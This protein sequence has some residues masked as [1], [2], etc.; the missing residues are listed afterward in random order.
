LNSNNLDLVIT[1]YISNNI[2]QDD[3][4]FF[5]SKLAILDTIGC[6]IEASSHKEVVEFASKNNISTNFQNPFRNLNF[7]E[8]YENISWYLTVL[9]R[10]FDY[11]DTFLAKEWA[12]P[13]D[14]FGTIYSYFYKNNNYK[15]YDFVNSLTKAYEIQ[16]SLCLGTSLNK[17]GYDHV[18]YVKLASGSVFSHL[19]NNGD[20]SATRRTVNNILLDGPS[21]RA[22]RH[23]P[24]VGKRKSWAAADAAKRG[25]ELA[26]ISTYKDE[27]YESVQNEDKWGFEYSF[28]DNT[29]LEIG[30]ELNNWVIQNTLFK[31]LFPAEFHGQSAV[32]AAIELSEEFNKNIN[33]VK[34]INIYTHEPAIRIISNKE[35]LKNASDRD[36]SLEYMVAAALL[37]GELKYEMYEENYP[38]FK[39][40]NNLRKKIYVTEEP[41]FTKDYY[42][43]TK[44]HISNSIEIVFDDNSISEKVTIENPIGHP[45]RREEAVPLLKDK[46]LR[47]VISVFEEEK[48]LE[49]WNKIINL[50]KDDDLNMFFNILNEDE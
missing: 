25:I 21:L 46:F 32:E 2:K 6:I 7:N 24:N 28:L 30:K 35:I 47:N 14:N 33:K 44:R 48:A 49:V 8:S 13:S 17:L 38:G 4:H 5:S 27:I 36:H 39:K 26:N 16:G 34:K 42:E 12:H 50:E 1:E 11:N 45:S 15:F 10:W 20:R 19:V 23:F 22:Y 31:V 41:Q 18:F 9:T 43:F 37:Y 3:N 40:I 29:K